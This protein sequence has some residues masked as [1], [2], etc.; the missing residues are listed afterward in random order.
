MGADQ[1][2]EAALRKEAVPVPLAQRAEVPD[3]TQMRKFRS[4]P[5]PV[6]KAELA[7][8]LEPKQKTGPGEVLHC[9][10]VLVA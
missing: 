5:S 1:R 6:H 7:R 9:M 4:V 2:D 10:K 3:P 8:G